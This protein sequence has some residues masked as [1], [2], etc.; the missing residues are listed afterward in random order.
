MT[1]SST[2]HNTLTDHFDTA[3]GEFGRRVAQVTPDRGSAP[4]PCSEWDVRALVNHIVNEM[5]WAPPLLAGQTI[6]EVGDRFDGDVLGADPVTAWREAA[7]EASRAVRAPGALDRTV[8]LSFGE[9]EAAEYVWQL[10]TDLTVHA[11]DLARGAGLDDELPEPLC[12]A[13][14]ATL[15]PQAEMLAQSGVFGTPVDVAA[16]ADAETRVLGMVGR[17]R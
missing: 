12:E 10:T 16:G 4:T 5:L 3:L 6:A 2:S 9:T 13:V 8:H 14:L 15:E 1:E 7:D 17:A 11:W